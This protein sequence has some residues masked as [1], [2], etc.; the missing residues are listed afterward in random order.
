[1][2]E[3]ILVCNG[4]LRSTPAGIP[5]IEGWINH[6]S[7]QEQLGNPRKVEC[8]I[9]FLAMGQIAQAI[10]QLPPEQKLKCKGFL[11]AKSQRY[12]QTLVLH[13]DAFELLN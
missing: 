10:A 7:T 9:P 11:A 6:L 2:I 1:L 3:G 12:R 5:V 4:T 8:E 13:I